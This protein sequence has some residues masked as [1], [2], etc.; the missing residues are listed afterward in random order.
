VAQ[1]RIGA[2][3]NLSLSEDPVARKDL[4]TSLAERAWALATEGG[5]KSRVIVFCD[6]R[7]DAGKVVDQLRRRPGAPPCELLVGERRVRE[8]QLVAQW[9]ERHGFQPGASEIVPGPAFL[10]AT[11]AGEVGVD[12]DAEHMV[13]DLVEWERMVQRLGRVNRRGEG[14]SRVEILKA[15]TEK[16]EAP[17]DR[18]KRSAAS[19][20]L[21]TR[22][23]EL[24]TGGRDAC[25][26]ALIALRSVAGCAALLEAATTPSPLRPA[27]TRALVDAWSLA[28]LEEHT[29]RPETGPWLR[30]WVEEEPQATVVWRRYLPWRAGG[31]PR[32]AEVDAFFEHAPPERE[33]QLEAPVWRIEKVLRERARSLVKAQP[34]RG[35]EPAVLVLTSALAL[36]EGFTLAQFRDFN[37]KDAVRRLADRVLVVAAS[38]GGLSADGLLDQ[39]AAG[40]VALPEEATAET[41]PTPVTLDGPAGMM[42]DRL[43]ILSQTA[44]TRPELVPEGWALAH[45]W[46][47]RLDKDGEPEEEIGIW[48][49]DAARAE[50]G[51]TRGKPQTLA[52]HTDEVVA[53]AE[54]LAARLGLDPG[55]RAMLSV[56]ARLHDAGK[57]SETWQ[58]AFGAPREGRPYAK[59]AAR[60]IN[61]ALLDGYRHEFGSLREAEADP[62]L[63]EM[64]PDLQ[65]LALHLIVAH[66][67]YGRPV[68]RYGGD[69]ERA[70]KVAL[71]FAR[72]QRRWGPWGLAWWEALLRAADAEASRRHER[73]AG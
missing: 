37:P 17:S 20:E 12:L 67:G 73:G 25:P 38:L 14:D 66:H 35:G 40:A 45:A 72:L 29:G 53:C 32:K 4:A 70:G 71:R 23:P 10:V 1:R 43:R 42:W 15:A 28:S 57:A 60:W 62:G 50:P 8:R 47:S 54:A 7:E 34:S 21:L 19:A 58:D 44:G 61:Q 48:T 24:P 56:A 26:R 18:E 9:I 31:Q 46:V 3:K 39:D 13:A 11:S 6:R 22:L 36:E 41:R 63:R 64:S 52:A 27:L 65:D 5:A 55:C 68:I 33:E 69:V 59:T 2:R 51:L 16:P 49:R 30:G